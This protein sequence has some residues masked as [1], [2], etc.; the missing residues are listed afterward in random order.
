MIQRELLDSPSVLLFE[1]ESLTRDD[2]L[3][4]VAVQETFFRQKSQIRWLSLGDT[5]TI[6]FHK[7]VKANLSKNIIYFFRD[8]NN[9]KITDPLRMKDLVVDF[10]T[11]L[12]GYR[13]Y[14]IRPYSIDHIKSL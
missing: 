5:N 2:W 3:F 9:T 4:L 10:Y 12:L 8:N 11:Q 7:S 6:F 1:A 14:S 13:D